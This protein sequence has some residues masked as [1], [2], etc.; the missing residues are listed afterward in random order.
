MQGDTVTLSA[1]DL[2]NRGRLLGLNGLTLEATTLT[3][4]HDSQLLSAGTAWLRAASLTSDGVWQAG[5]LLIHGGEMH[6]AGQLQSDGALEVT[7]ASDATGRGALVNTGT[8]VARGDGQ[9]Q[10]SQLVNGGA[11]A[12]GTLSVT[13]G[14]VSN[15]GRLLADGAM[16]VTAGQL[17][18]DG[19]L[20][21]GWLTL[22]GERLTNR[23]SLL[24]E[25]GGGLFL[26]DRLETGA[27]S[28]LLSN[29][30]WQVQAGTVV[31]QGGWQGSHLT[32]S[33]Q[34]LFN[35]GALLGV[36]GVSLTLAQDYRGEAGSEVRSNGRVALETGTLWQQG[37]IG[38]G[39]LWLTA[40]SLSNGG[41]LVGL[42]QLDV[43]SRGQLDNAGSVLG[44]GAVNV[45]AAALD[46]GGVLQGD[47]LTLQG[48]QVTNRGRLQGTSALTLSGLS[49]YDG[50]AG[51]LLLSDG[52][53]TL[54]AGVADNAGGW[55]ARSLSLDGDTLI[56]R[57]TV[58]GLERL[59]L[60][61]KQLTNAG[62]IQGGAQTTLTGA[63][64]EN[65][66]TLLAQGGLTADYRERVSNGAGGRLLSGGRGAL[67]TGTLDNRGLWQSSQLELTAGSLVNGGTLLGV[68]GA[69]LT[70]AGRYSGLAGSELLSNGALGLTASG[71][72]NAGQVQGQ[73]VTLRAG[74]L[75]NQGGLT[76]TGQLTATLDGAL[77]NLS[78][79]LIRGGGL[80]LDAGTV[81]NAGRLEGQRE[82][83]VVSRGMVNNPGELVSGGTLSL[84]GSQLTNTGWLQGPAVSLSV[85]QLE[86]S[87]ALQA[88]QSLTLHLPQ[89]TNTGRVQAD[90]LTVITDGALENRGTLLGLTQLALQAAALNNTATGRLY[91]AGGLQLSTGSL[92]QDGQLVALGDLR[93]DI[94][95][96]MMFT[97]TLAAGGQL[98]LNV[99]G[100]LVQAGTLQGNGVTVTSTG[101]LTQ[102][103]RIVAGGGESRLTAASLV[104]EE[105]GTIQAGGPLS[106]VSG[107]DLVN[108]GF[109]GTA[110]DL[111][112]RA[113]GR[114]E[115][116]S[117]LYG[118]GNVLLLSDALVNRLGN[119]LAG[120]SL[121]IQ[122][123]EAGNASGSVLNSSGTIET[124]RGDIT[125]RTGTLT[126]QR[127]GLTVTESGSTAAEI[128]DWA[129]GTRV[130]IPVSWFGEGE[131]GI[132]YHP[133]RIANDITDI[134]ADY[135][136]YKE[137]FIK[138]V[139][140]SKETVGVYS[141]GGVGKINSGRN[142]SINASKLSNISSLLSANNDIYMI[143]N[144]LNNFSYQSGSRESY[145]IYEY[146]QSVTPNIGIKED[147]IR[148]QHINLEPYIYY[149]LSSRDPISEFVPGQSYTA[150]IQAGGSINASFS[151][152]IS[153]TS[154]QPGSGG[155][156]PSLSAPSLGGVAALST[157]TAQSDRGL[158]GAAGGISTTAVG[159][160]GGVALAG[161]GAGLNSGYSNVARS[162]GVPGGGGSA[163]PGQTAVGLSSGPVDST[164]PVTGATVSLP[165]AVAPGGLS[166]GPVDGTRPVTGATV[167]LPGAVATGGLSGGPVDGT[168]PVT[169]ATVSLP[170]AVAPGGLSGG[171]VDGTRPVTGAT[172]NL[173][174]AVATGGL[175]SGPVDGTR[176]VTG[177][178]VNLPGAVTPGSLSSGPVDGTRPVTGGTVSPLAG[179]TPGQ[180]QQAMT[181][182]LAPVSG[183]TLTDYPLPASQNGLFVADTASD[184]RY[185]I[186]S[187]PMLTRLGQVDNGLFADLQGLL[188]Q[189]PAT[190]VPVETR[191]LLTDRTQILGS[192]YLLG[193]LNLDAEHDYRFLGDAA[194]DTRYISNA[195]LS[196]TGQRYLGGLGSELAQMQWLMDNAVAA[197]TALNLQLG[198]SLSPAQ[199]AGLSHSILW[200]E[201]V[202][203]GGQTVLAPKLYLAQAD[204]TNLQGSRIVANSV[205]LSAGG[206]IDNRGSTMQGGQQL[207]LHSG[208]TV[209]NREG[210]LLSAD[211][212]LNVV[213]F[214][215]LTNISATVTGGQVSLAS[216]TGDILNRTTLNTWQT[217]A[218]DGRGT[219]S[220]LRTDVGQ[221]GLIQARD[222]LTL[223][224]GRDLELAGAQLASGGAMALSAGRDLRLTALTT[225][226]GTVNVQGGDTHERREQ[227]L[228]QSQLA[229][230]GSLSLQAGQDIRA[231]AAA[232]S[233]GGA[234]ALSAGRDLSLLSGSE[235]QFSQNA[236]NRHLDWQQTQT[237]QSTVLTAG[238]GLSLQAGQDIRVQG[239]SL[240]AGGALT[241]LAGRDLSL[242]SATERQHDFFEETTVKKKAFSKT[243]THTVRDTEQSTEKGTLLSAGSV[244]LLAGRDIGV[245]GSA[246]AADGD[247]TLA[248]G[249][250]L[251]TSAGTE[252]YRQ[253]EEVSRKKSG[254]FSG[255]GLGFTIGSTSLR[256]TLDAAGVTQSQSV[257]TLGSTG[258]TVRLSAG[259][260][261]SLTATDVMAARD[262]QVTGERVTL[263]P[264]HDQ[265]SQTQR[266]EQKTAGLTVALSGV[267]GAAINAGVQAVQ[268]A[269]TQ[270]DSRLRALEGMKAAL[271]GYQAYQ[272]TQLDTNNLGA[273]SFVGISV[274]L[275]SQRAASS[276]T[277]EQW[278]SFASTLNAGHDIS[279]VAREGDITAVG[280]QMK[281]AN[282]VALNASRAINLLSARNTESMSGSNHSSGGNI[283]VSVGLSNG[284]AGFSVFANG[285]AAS[286]REL[287]SGNS[288]SETTVDAGH[289]VS[290]TSGGDTRLTGAQVSGERIVANV[291]GDLRLASQQDS[292]RYD[293]TQT[294]VS[295][296]GSLTVGSMTGSAYLGASRD[297]LRSRFDSVQQQTGLFA[298]QGGYDIH[299]G[300]HTQ[301]DGAV[302]G[303]TASAENNRLETGTLG[304]GN[305]DNRAEFSVSHSGGG[306]SL[307]TAP[308][309]MDALKTAAMTTPSALMSLG[310]GGNAASTTYAAVS[311]G[312]LIIRNPGGQQQDV[313]GLSRDAAHAANGLS[314]LFDKEQQRLQL[315]QSV[316]AL[317]GQVMEVVRTAGDIRATQ[318]AEAS[319]K[320]DRLP[321]T[322][323]EAAWDKYRKDLA[324]T[325]AYKAVMA[326][327]GT[328]SDVQRGLQ[329]A[330]AAL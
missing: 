247:L 171:P 234:M 73:T 186:R 184:S 112:L 48:G 253:F 5:R 287:G 98:T 16:T 69:T 266:L 109:I 26:S 205:S 118:A 91:S 116:G 301:L 296:G 94:G 195:V 156:M 155:F 175:S 56:N 32:L 222:G 65:S 170:G 283:G 74:A 310:R 68:D 138:K 265:H 263:D 24:A 139:T 185:L 141:Q 99:A 200:W 276:Q 79:A 180:A 1:V 237:Q 307:S 53:A 182:A 273:S 54:T 66:G 264:G 168:R 202:S 135:A 100:D 251:T 174:G 313:A 292:N 321:D 93:A 304:F 44:N 47:T 163:L 284:G 90:R 327:Y 305:I 322:A 295:A 208:G 15:T 108:R 89:W 316:G 291:G 323:S 52:A 329:A 299:V 12:A 129:G 294:S 302:I 57:G 189:T 19:R 63:V 22:T 318:A 46:N 306:I 11:L 33:A 105:T 267:V 199:V 158:S 179:L 23:G 35:W 140:I 40:G 76:G 133:S 282:N 106:L 289:Q 228:L 213:A 194:F 235:S 43:A 258:G 86:N 225:E 3:T 215:N 122:R 58:S 214:G 181:Q 218:K 160:T 38:G 293:S 246:V 297:K 134:W 71:V 167:S 60:G 277:H 124:Q 145:L 101:R 51:S 132:Y 325:P 290:L 221:A 123:D 107:S 210:G 92:A 219:G 111:L 110:G 59:R 41:R 62:Q 274:S 128:P 125:V 224:A 196:Q 259:Q 157:E 240:Q 271:S 21:S 244:S 39:Q 144:D 143:G 275:G 198:V 245:Q 162:G 204:K 142:I 272:G 166:S 192:D 191:P 324:E 81:W 232:L 314:P 233:A 309:L 183:P 148:S 84:S 9:L 126:N 298:G 34:Q 7:L 113:A 25:Q 154:L 45:S 280:S 120:N 146:K 201:S 220:L 285:N 303:S 255:G 262:I 209:S 250:D 206:D 270:S 28:A 102:Q 10:V 31:H 14:Q 64:F 278:Q 29:G 82:L 187:N 281:A 85:G 17:E 226:R 308:G 197:K 97:R 119:I 241:A 279:V 131:I 88:G 153:N 115:N 13:A 117:L 300:N 72:D 249:R 61:V 178:T 173:P 207:A 257:S 268:A 159:G 75:R 256:Q 37:D 114:I 239:S 77:E 229:S 238:T 326:S 36:S 6:N 165:G 203:V 223:Q 172:V 242:L 319:G 137:Y 236:W 49:R 311:E 8:L 30:D 136:P 27:A 288:W 254:I 193:K 42:S 211:G 18:N 188:G 227:G 67:T 312:A 130:A 151:Q 243:V 87:G 212:S 147:F 150:T 152:N 80:T 217:A 320:V 127:E 169:G 70:L 103:G 121:W 231:T 78:G 315:A 248:A 261:V 317:G 4:G 260:Q 190:T 286:G 83:G 216:V 104:Q 96:P 161:G 230:G 55:Q 328:G 269:R 176:P 20:E 50:T 330:T 95:S 164:R 149:S 177:A 2:T 252:T